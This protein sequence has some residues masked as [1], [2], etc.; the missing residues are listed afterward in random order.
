M[1]WIRAQDE[2]RERRPGDIARCVVGVL[3]VLFAG[4]WANAHP[5]VEAKVVQLFNGLSKGLGIASAPALAA[6]LVFRG[7][8]FLLPPIFGFFTLRWLRAKGLA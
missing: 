3:G 6:V 5:G 8:T 7:V 4:L 1:S 2:Q